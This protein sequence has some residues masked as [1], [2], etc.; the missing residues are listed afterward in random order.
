[1]AGRPAKSQVHL[2]LLNYVMRHLTHLAQTSP[3][4]LAVDTCFSEVSAPAVHLLRDTLRTLEVYPPTG[5]MR[6]P[7]LAMRA[8]IHLSLQVVDSGTSDPYVSAEDGQLRSVQ[9]EVMVLPR[10]SAE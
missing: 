6:L 8:Q 10:C 1:M 5:D 7:K 4:R 2:P 3:E 9:Q